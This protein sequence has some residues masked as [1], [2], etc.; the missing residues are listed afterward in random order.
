[1]T[2]RGVQDFSAGSNCR[3]GGNSRTRIRIGVWRCARIAVISWQNFNG[4]GS[5][6]LGISKENGCL[7][8]SAPRE[9]EMT[10]KDL[11]HYTN[12]VDKVAARFEKTDSNTERNSTVGKIQSN[13]TSCYGEIVHERKS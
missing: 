9:D 8:Q 10:T 4:S 2:L 1:M 7:R 5:C 6:F 12:L 13:S 3:C 11:E